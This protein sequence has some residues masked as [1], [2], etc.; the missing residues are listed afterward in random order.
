M[1]IHTKGGAM[2]FGLCGG[3]LIGKAITKFRVKRKIE[4]L[5]DISTRDEE[6]YEAIIRNCNKELSD[7]MHESTRRYI[8]S[9]KQ[10]Y[11]EKKSAAFGKKALLNGLLTSLEEL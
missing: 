6:Y 11:I 1:A 5:K 9:N 7:D 3:Y 8:E 4:D 2:V 10:D